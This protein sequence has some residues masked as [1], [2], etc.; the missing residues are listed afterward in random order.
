MNGAGRIGCGILHGQRAG[1]GLDR[2]AC[3]TIR[4]TQHGR[5]LGERDT[6]FGGPAAELAWE[7]IAALVKV[8]GA[9]AFA[10]T[11]SLS[12]GLEDLAAAY[13]RLNIQRDDMWNRY[14]CFSANRSGCE[15]WVN[16]TN[17][18][19]NKKA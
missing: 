8:G 17:E 1:D 12:Q 19:K 6:R 4:T 10:R 5:V 14:S 15:V 3:A 7:I 9:R 16:K 2:G 13:A 11:L 18:K